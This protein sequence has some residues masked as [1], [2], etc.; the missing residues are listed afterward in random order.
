MKSLSITFLLLVLGS[1]LNVS[2]ETS[3]TNN[4]AET[5]VAHYEWEFLSAVPTQIYK[6]EERVAQLKDLM[7]KYYITKEDVIPGDPM[8]RTIVLKPKVYY[9]VNSIEKHLKRKIK[10]G[11]ITKEQASLKLTHILE[12]ALSIAMDSGEESQSFEIALKDA[13]RIEDQI[14]LFNKVKLQNIYGA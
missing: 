11:A 3:L 9:S 6:I 5:E 13:K 10:K 7:T 12:V 4:N 8:M 1:T 14:S 2:A